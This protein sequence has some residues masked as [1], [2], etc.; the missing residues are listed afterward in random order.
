L[1]VDRIQKRGKYCQILYTGVGLAV[2]F[3]YDISRGKNAPGAVFN[4]K[5]KKTASLRIKT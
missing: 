1:P 3:F 2:G 4:T 5:K